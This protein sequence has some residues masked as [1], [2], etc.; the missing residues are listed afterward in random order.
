[1]LTD[2]PDLTRAGYQ[3]GSIAPLRAHA[4]VTTYLRAFFQSAFDGS[5]SPLLQGPNALF[6]EV[7]FR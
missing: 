2:Y 4:I 3:L 1:V 7:T 5:P 6:P